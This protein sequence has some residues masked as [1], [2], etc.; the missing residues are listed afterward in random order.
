MIEEDTTD[1]VYRLKAGEE[2]LELAA[3]EEIESLREVAIQQLYK[4]VR[5]RL[6]IE[7]MQRKIYRMKFELAR[8]P[9]NNRNPLDP[10]KK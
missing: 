1:I 6:R 2:A 4:N 8:N 7:K 10:V 3:A 5:L 9:K